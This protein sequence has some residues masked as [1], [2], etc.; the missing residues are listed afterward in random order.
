M[1]DPAAPLVH[2]PPHDSSTFLSSAWAAREYNGRHPSQRRRACN[3]CRQQKLK[4]SSAADT[5]DVSLGAA[6]CSRCA[7]LGLECKVDESFQRTRKRRR[8]ADFESEIAALKRQLQTYMSQTPRSTDERPQSGYETPDRAAP[9][10]LSRSPVADKRTPGPTQRTPSLVNNGLLPRMPPQDPALQSLEGAST[11]PHQHEIEPPVSPAG[12]HVQPKP[13]AL[14]DT[15][16][17]FDESEIEQLYKT[18]ISDYHPTMPVIDPNVPAQQCCESSPLLFWCIMA[19]ASRRGQKYNLGKLSHA[20]MNMLWEAI[21]SVPHSVHLV[22][23]ILLIS[24]WP[25][26]TSSS[27]TDP[28]YVLTHNAVSA[29]IQLGLHRPQHQQ[30]FAKYRLRLTEREVVLRANLWIAC[31]VVAQSVSVG[32]GLQSPSHLQDWAG[33]LESTYTEALPSTLRTLLQ[34]ELFR[35]KVLTTML[36]IDE[37]DAA[38]HAT[39]LRLSLYRMLLNDWAV[40]ETTVGDSNSR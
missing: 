18:F 29:S 6:K 35:H 39:S 4:C 7:K 17:I 2:V 19:I 34:I 30:D 40:L 13:R 9:G 11:Q 25:F 3:E 32:V 15:G 24:T 28:T 21:R 1:T 22:Q 10:R 37:A 31:N 36:S 38:T 8:S 5:S 26:P 33:V 14:L 20:I 12:P 23:A 16:V 27:A